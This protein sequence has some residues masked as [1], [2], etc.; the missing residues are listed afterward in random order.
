MS[1]E[2]LSK[3]KFFKMADFGGPYLGPGKEYWKCEGSFKY[4]LVYAEK[5][6]TIPIALA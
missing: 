3:T 1:Y 6:E 4:K 2:F 5:N